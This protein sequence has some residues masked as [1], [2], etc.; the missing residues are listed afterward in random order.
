MMRIAV[1]LI[2]ALLLPGESLH[3]ADRWQMQYFHD[4][5]RE[6]LR[7]MAFAF[8]SA[9]RGVAVGAIV[10][11]DDAKPAALVTSDQGET[12]TL[13]RPDEA[14]HALF[15]LDE[16]SGWML[17][18]SGIWY[19]DE[20]GRSWRRIHKQKGLTD[21]RFVSP[22]RG[23]AIG[24]DKT[25]IETSDAGKTWAPV[26]AAEELDMAKERTVFD[27]IEF[28]TPKV[29]MITGKSRLRDSQSTPLWLDPKPQRRRELPALSVL[30]ETKDGGATWTSQK[31]SMFGRIAR[32]HL[33]ADGRGLAL[34]RFDG[35]FEH[36]SE[37]YLLD[38]RSGKNSP[39]L[40]KKD[41]SIT[42]IF[43]GETSYAA[44]FLPPG[45]LAE[46]PV[47]GKVRI[48]RS[49]NLTDWTEDE[50]DYRAVAT[51]VSLAN[52]GDQMW[53]ATDTGMILK[54]VSDQ[55]AT[56]INSPGQ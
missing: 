5:D 28:A 51:R 3:S 16:T 32:I 15:F 20:C 54:L 4:E 39:V 53:A 43:L 37:L 7:I 13:T 41:M 29:G 56:S 31:V 11:G 8:C 33:S 10:E 35:F 52:A 21:I 47:P 25:V 46:S 19:T 14:G 48:V 49:A 44:G 55:N 1:L 36:P 30:L 45:A 9:K 42:D 40:Q 17:T 18:E 22:E 34:I 26:K 38:L 27:A 50:V 12:W 6:R 2:G 23:W 24:A